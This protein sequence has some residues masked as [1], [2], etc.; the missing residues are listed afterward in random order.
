M[1]KDKKIEGNDILEPQF[2]VA[3]EAIEN[4]KV[5]SEPVEK[6]P[7]SKKKSKYVFGYVTVPTAYLRAE[8][9]EDSMIIAI[10]R[11]G[12]AMIVKD[13]TPD[14]YGGTIGNTLGYI[15]KSEMEIR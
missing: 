9:D 6:K 15:S 2:E 1:A 13:E 5:V 14:F 4:E 8:A 12:E 10:V 7:T 11:D 3:E